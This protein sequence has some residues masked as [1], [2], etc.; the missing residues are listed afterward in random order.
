MVVRGTQR[1]DYQSTPRRL[2]EAET[3]RFLRNLAR[4]AIVVDRAPEEDGGT[5]S[6]APHHLTAYDTSYLELAERQAMPLA[7]LDAPL[8]EGGAA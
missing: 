3:A 4:T 8:A 7:T 5:D 6:S 1:A 2:R